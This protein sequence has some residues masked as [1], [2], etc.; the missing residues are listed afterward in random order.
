MSRLN[1]AGQPNVRFEQVPD[2]EA[3][4]PPGSPRPTAAIVRSAHVDG[5]RCVPQ[6]DAPPAL[7]VQPPVPS[8]LSLGRRR[9]CWHPGWR[10]AFPAPTSNDGAATTATYPGST[11]RH[12]LLT[13]FN[14]SGPSSTGALGRCTSAGP[15]LGSLSTTWRSN[16]YALLTAPLQPRR[17]MLDPRDPTSSLTERQI[18]WMAALGTFIRAAADRCVRGEPLAV[19]AQGVAALTGLD[20]TVFCC[21]H[22]VMMFVIPGCDCLRKW[23]NLPRAV[24]LTMAVDS[25]TRCL[26]RRICPMRLNSRTLWSSRRSRRCTST[27]YFMRRVGCNVDSFTCLRLRQ[28]DGVTIAHHEVQGPTVQMR[29]ANSPQQTALSTVIVRETAIGKFRKQSQPLEDV[30]E[31]IA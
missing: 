22:S 8:R 19:S 26:L 13:R 6:A 7:A 17:R 5:R 27:L 3:P 23:C 14:C 16:E 24:S 28:L 21:F 18:R 10:T 20:G 15:T 12:G 4:A 9:V 1:A 2:P 30:D 11:C 31:N 29:W 25:E